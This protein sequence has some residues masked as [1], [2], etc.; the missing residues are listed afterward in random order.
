MPAPSCS[1]TSWL[2]GGPRGAGEHAHA[3]E[4]A[5][6]RIRDRLLTATPDWSYRGE[7][8]EWQEGEDGHHVW[9]VDPNDG[10]AAYL[11]GWRGSAV[12][13]GLLRDGV[14]VLGVVYAF[15]APDNAGDLVAWAEG[16]GPLRRNGDPVERG[17]LPDSLSPEV[18]VGVSPAPISSRCPTHAASR[19]PAG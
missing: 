17:Q 13:I 18:F 1:P 3:D 10:T 19:P 16:C 12:S 15:A 7:E 11:K 8:T 2:P 4:E 14:P 9:L 5:E 6:A